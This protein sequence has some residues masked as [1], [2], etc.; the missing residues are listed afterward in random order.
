MWC[1]WETSHGDPEIT[2][3]VKGIVTKLSIFKSISRV[4]W[5]QQKSELQQQMVPRAYHGDLFQF[6]HR[7]VTVKRL[8]QQKGS[9]LWEKVLSN[10]HI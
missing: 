4:V 1:S 10:W 8:D 5:A 7:K 6:I 2:A 9:P 3:W